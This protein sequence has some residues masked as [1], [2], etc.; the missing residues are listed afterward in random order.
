MTSLFKCRRFVASNCV[1]MFCLIGL[2]V[3]PAQYMDICDVP[4]RPQMPFRALF[5]TRTRILVESPTFRKEKQQ[6]IPKRTLTAENELRHF[7]F[8]LRK[9]LYCGNLFL[10]VL[11]FFWKFVVFANQIGISAPWQTSLLPMQFYSRMCRNDVIVT[12][13]ILIWRKY[14]ARDLSSTKSFWHG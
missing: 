14:R 3:T 13:C 2:Y 9:S 4:R 5:Q 7:L 1:K 10:F 6:K 8:D 11:S 12:H